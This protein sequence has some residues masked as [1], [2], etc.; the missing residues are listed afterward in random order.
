MDTEIK[1]LI[2]EDSPDDAH[3]L[4]DEITRAGLKIRH[5]RVDTERTMRSALE[6]EPWD[7]ILCDYSIPNFGALPALKLAKEMKI[8]VPFIVI[9]GVM[10]EETAISVMKAGAHD[11]ITKGNYTRLVPAIQR[12]IAE[13]VIRQKAVEE[14]KKQKQLA[15]TMIMQ[16]PMPLI[17]FST[18]LD[19][20]LANEA[21]LALCGW[22][23]ER[24]QKMSMKE[25][26]VL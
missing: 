9:S 16:N 21:F 8:K 24:L 11:F 18:N 13:Y 3:L 25:F 17:I 19:I 1:L 14:A 15:F 26:K 12:E 4:V 23:E 7:V 2:V 20:K 6:R 22:S 5:E 10:G